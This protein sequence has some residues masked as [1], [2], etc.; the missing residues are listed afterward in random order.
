MAVFG[1]MRCKNSGTGHTPPSHQI[2]RPNKKSLRIKT[3]RRSGGQPG[4]EGSTLN[5][6]LIG[7]PTESASMAP[8]ATW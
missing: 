3:D 2:A 6:L 1:R 8:M 4:H 5:I 7:N